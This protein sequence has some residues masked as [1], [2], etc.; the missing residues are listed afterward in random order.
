MKTYFQM[1]PGIYSLILSLRQHKLPDAWDT[2][3]ELPTSCS[4]LR[5]SC[6]QKR[7]IK[8]Y[9]EIKIALQQKPFDH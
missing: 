7:F 1:E 5:D 8:K 9:I 6:S 2:V 4:A 3:N